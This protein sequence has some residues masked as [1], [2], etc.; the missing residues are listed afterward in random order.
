MDV[1]AITRMLIAAV[2]PEFIL[3]FMAKVIIDDL[4]QASCYRF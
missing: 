3:A 4:S 2:L 1:K